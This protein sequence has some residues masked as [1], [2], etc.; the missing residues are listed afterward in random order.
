MKSSEDIDGAL[1]KHSFLISSLASL[2]ASL[3]SCSK[4]ENKGSEV[5]NQSLASQ[6]HRDSF[7]EN[8][9]LGNSFSN[10][11]RSSLVI[12]KR[13]FVKI[14]HYTNGDK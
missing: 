7:I 5:E 1:F 3:I 6:S 10:L 11:S 12:V 8:W 9:N 13:L 4:K 14:V 2:S